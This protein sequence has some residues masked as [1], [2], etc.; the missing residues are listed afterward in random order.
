MDLAVAL[1]DGARAGDSSTACR[2]DGTEWLC[3]TGANS[4]LADKD[5]RCL[6]EPLLRRMAAA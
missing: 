3:S 2:H 6:V 1:V 5:R 4:P